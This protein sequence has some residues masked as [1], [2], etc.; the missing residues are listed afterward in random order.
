[1]FSLSPDTDA[2]KI[3]FSFI[4]SFCLNDINVR[5]RVSPHTLRHRVWPTQRDPRRCVLVIC[6]GGDTDVCGVVSTLLW[7][8]SSL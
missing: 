4:K 2:L 6:C 5:L 7:L 8:Q 3:D 1:M